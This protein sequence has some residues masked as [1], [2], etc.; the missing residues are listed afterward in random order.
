MAVRRSL[1]SYVITLNAFAVTMMP[2][3]VEPA[4]AQFYTSCS[5]IY[6]SGAIN[7]WSNPAKCVCQSGYRWTS[8]GGGLRCV[9]SDST[10][11][12]SSSERTSSERSSGERSS[13]ERTTTRRVTKASNAAKSSDDEPSNAKEANSKDEIEKIQDG[14]NLLGYDA[15]N[16][17]GKPGQRTTAA[18]KTYQ[19]EKG[20]PKT[21]YMSAAEIKILSDDVQQKYKT[22]TAPVP[23]PDPTSSGT[24]ATPTT[25][26][27]KTVQTE[28]T[29]ATKSA[30]SVPQQAATSVGAVASAKTAQAER[31]DPRIELAHWDTVRNS[32]S[33]KEL[34][35]YILRFPKGEFTT[36]ASMRLEAVK[37]EIAKANGKDVNAKE[38]WVRRFPSKTGT[39]G[40][41]VPAAAAA[42]QLIPVDDSIYPRARVLRRDAVAV[43]IGN[44]IYG[45][46]VPRVDYAIRDAEA[47]KAITIKSLGLEPGNVIFLK[48]ATRSA[49]DDV[50]G[51]D[52]DHRGKLWRLIDPDGQSDVFVFYSGHGVP[53]VNGNGE[54]L[55]LPVDGDPKHANINGYPLAQLYGNLEK[56]KTRSTTVFLDTCFSGQASDAGATPLIK[57]ASPV[58]IAK[59]TPSDATRINV[60][61]AAGERQLSS[62]DKDAQHG[63]FTKFVLAGLT[64]E[65]DADKNR[66]I[67]AQELHDYVSRQ[68]RRAAR[69]SHGREQEPQFTGAGSFV[70]SSY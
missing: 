57:E 65:A 45:K 63:T 51:N 61:A 52:R 12:S 47:M 27:P 7:N 10:S 4:R 67:T 28:T 11:S 62:W 43:I 19:A 34:E 50:F 20:F 30:S 5:S 49:M 39:A 6:G 58:L 13:G 23:Q 32:K 21:G 35:D 42:S 24:T 66:E 16:V 29:V 26:T 56:L 70:I 3:A 40:E 46:D 37:A 48:D 33:Q 18:I 25:A 1:I 60:F 8:S 31:P 41:A 55:L 44:S 14:L 53:S 9:P 68:V 36:L 69:R 64:G 22:A 17:D 15:G 2:A 59:A 38:D 54:N